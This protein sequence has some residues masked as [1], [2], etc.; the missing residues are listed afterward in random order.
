MRIVG[1][2]VPNRYYVKHVD[3]TG[4]ALSMKKNC[5]KILKIGGDRAF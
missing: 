5:K 3:S 1:V 2:F 4:T